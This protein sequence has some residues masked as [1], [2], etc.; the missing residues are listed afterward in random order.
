LS[1]AAVAGLNAGELWNVVV[2]PVP[3]NPNY[4]VPGFD[5]AVDAAGTFHICCASVEQTQDALTYLR[6]SPGGLQEQVTLSNKPRRTHMP[7]IALTSTGEPVVLFVDSD[8]VK[9]VKRSAGTWTSEVLSAF[10][11]YEFADL[12]LAV[13]SKGRAHALFNG[14]NFVDTVYLRYMHETETG[15]ATY[16]FVPLNPLYGDHGQFHD[17][18]LSEDGRPHIVYQESSAE[19]TG[20]PVKYVHRNSEGDFVVEQVSDNNNLNDIEMVRDAD[21]VL[22]VVHPYGNMILAYCRRSVDGVWREERI[23]D[24]RTGR[25]IQYAYADIALEEGVPVIGYQANWGLLSTATLKAG[26]WNCANLG[27]QLG[28]F[29]PRL[30]Q[31]HRGRLCFMHGSYSKI[32]LIF[33]PASH[34]PKVGISVSGAGGISIGME[35]MTAGARYEL[36]Q[37][38]DLVNWNRI[39]EFP[40]STGFQSVEVPVAGDRGYFRVELQR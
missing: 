19:Q 12:S 17:L 36:M 22:H 9:L 7:K 16:D 40:G 35:G 20:H 6:W 23:I 34:L 18:L 10:G 24:P 5:F 25:D 38:P 29:S 30:G 37:S 3:T 31:D 1:L 14:S 13:D 32:G 28:A 21:G 33:P 8:G 11:H 2:K 26:A 4:V 39:R 15:W 27:Y